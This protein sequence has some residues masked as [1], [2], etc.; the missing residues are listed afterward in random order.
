MPARSIAPLEAWAT[1]KRL[2]LIEDEILVALPFVERFLD[3]GVQVLGPIATLDRA[4]AAIERRD[5][6][7]AVL[8]V[9]LSGSLS[10]PAG[11]ALLEANVPFLFVTGYMDDES[12]PVHLRKVPR[13][14]K[15]ADPDSVLGRLQELWV[16]ARKA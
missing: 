15:P 4:L 9:N 8:D 5:F 6:D 11:F 3:L 13:L 12:F 10:W 1:G 7:A 2:L 14:T 16:S